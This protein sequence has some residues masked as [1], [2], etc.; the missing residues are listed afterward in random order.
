MPNLSLSPFISQNI[1]L[2]CVI[3][4]MTL[5]AFYKG[6]KLLYCL[7]IAFFP[8]VLIYQAFTN[9][10]VFTNMLPAG[11]F[12]G[13]FNN[14]LGFYIVVFIFCLY[15]VNKI[16]TFDI[17]RYGIHRVIDSVLLAAGMVSESF[18]LIFHTLA[19]PDFYHFSSPVESFLS[20]TSAYVIMLVFAMFAVLYSSRA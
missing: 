11:F 20:T 7:L 4:A 1:V 12:A 3:L 14:R 13:Q 5:L 10:P 15:I 9:W 6:R 2:G 19:G 16:I 18:I 17:R 8:A